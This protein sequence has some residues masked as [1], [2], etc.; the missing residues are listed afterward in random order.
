MG[1]GEDEDVVMLY[2]K[3]VDEASA[4]MKPSSDATADPLPST[5]RSSP[6]FS[7]P[8]PPTPL[9]V[10]ASHH[11]HSIIRDPAGHDLDRSEDR[12]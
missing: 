11:H 12:Y 7:S 3:N 8:S 9:L 1:R 2:V 4:G 6:P 5:P 10:E